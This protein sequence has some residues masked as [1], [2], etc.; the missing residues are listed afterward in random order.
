MPVTN[1]ASRIVGLIS[2][3]ICYALVHGAHASYIHQATAAPAQVMQTW[4]S[5]QLQSAAIMVAKF[6][7]IFVNLMASAL[8]QRMAIHALPC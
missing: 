7:C 4:T 1:I 8:S 6:A 5:D 3:N 2:R